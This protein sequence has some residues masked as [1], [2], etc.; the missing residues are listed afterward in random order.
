MEELSRDLVNSRLVTVVDWREIDLVRGELLF[1]LSGEVSDES[2]R[3][4]GKMLGAEAVVSGSLTDVGNACRC[5]VKAIDVESAALE[6]SPAFDIARRD[7]RLAYLLD[8]ATVRR[9]R[10]AD[11]DVYIAG[12]GLNAAGNSVACY[13]KNGVNTDLSD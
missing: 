4:I 10:V 7:S 2:A 5:G 1:Q 9:K 3:S 8:R 11:V 13:W 6:F 12:S